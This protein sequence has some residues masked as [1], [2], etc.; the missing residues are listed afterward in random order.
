MMTVLNTQKQHCHKNLHRWINWARWEKS[1][2]EMTL[3][4]QRD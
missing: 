3:S 4:S 1:F 2:F